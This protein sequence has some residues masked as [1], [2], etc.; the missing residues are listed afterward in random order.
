MGEA[1]HNVVVEMRQEEESKK[2]KVTSAHEK[3][4]I[5]GGWTDDIGEGEDSG[6][7][8][9]PSAHTV[10]PANPASGPSAHLLADK[11]MKKE[12][13][14]TIEADK[15]KMETET[16]A[17]TERNATEGQ[18]MRSQDKTEMDQKSDEE[19]SE[20]KRGGEVRDDDHGG[21]RAE[22]DRKRKVGKSAASVEVRDSEWERRIPS[23]SS[24]ENESKENQHVNATI[25]TTPTIITTTEQA[26]PSAL[27]SA[28]VDQ[29]DVNRTFPSLS[30]IQVQVRGVNKQSSLLSL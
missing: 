24:T 13:Q 12:E 15:A 14:R 25:S 28:T 7:S 30:R 3:K 26:P 1:I 2:E 22:Q 20:E 11:H 27:L 21:D 29:N 23:P 8:N 16:K 18:S 4:E 19:E 6:L 5:D 9:Q 17:E 10:M